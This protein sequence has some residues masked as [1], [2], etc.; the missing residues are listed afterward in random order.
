MK[1]FNYF[2]LGFLFLQCDQKTASDDLNELILG[3]EN[4]EAYDRELFP[5]GD[6]SEERFKKEA[7]F[8]STTL[9]RLNTI[10]VDQL[11]NEDLISFELFQFVLE[12]NLSAFGFKTH[13]NPILSD[14]GFHNNL[15]FIAFDPLAPLRKTARL[16]RPSQGHAA[17][18]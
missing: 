5:L 7:D 11:S 16:S 18:C 2:L 12:A 14:A 3:Y 1:Y 13:Y 17:F 6:F 10:A 4:F 8:W 9:D 15:V